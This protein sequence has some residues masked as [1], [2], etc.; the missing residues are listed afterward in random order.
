MK[1]RLLDL[2]NAKM[3]ERF[4]ISLLI[5]ESFFAT[6]A[7]MR[8]GNLASMNIIAFLFFGLCYSFF[9]YVKK[10][11]KILSRETI[12]NQKIVAIV[13]GLIFT[14]FYLS[15]THKKMVEDLNNKLFQMVI[16]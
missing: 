16:L 2:N 14:I 15:D 4:G 3:R 7:I 5:I 8:I 9:T 1:A 11:T 10:E 6:W 12:R 13:L